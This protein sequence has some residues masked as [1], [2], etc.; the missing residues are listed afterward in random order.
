MIDIMEN[1][2]NWKNIND[3]ITYYKSLDYEYIEVPWI[4]SKETVSIT[5]P[6]ESRLFETFFGC[7][8][9]SGEQSFLQIRKELCP[10]KSYQCVTP[11]FRDEKYDNF[12]FPQF[13]KNELIHVLWKRENPNVVLQKIIK[14]A[15][16]FFRVG[17]VV[18]TKIGFDI[19]IDNIEVGS[20]G[21]REY[22][23]FSWVYGTGC[24]EPRLTQVLTIRNRR[25]DDEERD[26]LEKTYQ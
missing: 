6:P 18:E 11:C 1:H 16:G 3:S 5:S 21:I 12:H 14:D 20:Y 25:L 10:A 2:I 7:L 4:V 9:A 24:A 17:T 23:D 22:K 26:F 8:V 13:M 15:L 19:E